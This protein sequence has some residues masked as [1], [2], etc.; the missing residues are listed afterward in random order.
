MSYSSY[1]LLF[2]QC[3]KEGNKENVE[4]TVI[5]ME[6]LECLKKLFYRIELSY[7]FHKDMLKK[8]YSSNFITMRQISFN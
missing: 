8:M 2:Y 1:V 5:I 3:L 4:K 7:K 6:I